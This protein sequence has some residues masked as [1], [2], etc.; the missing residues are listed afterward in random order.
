MNAQPHQPDR[1]TSQPPSQSPNQPP[2]QQG[3]AARQFGAQ[4]SAYL[5]SAVHSQGADLDALAELVRA[6]PGCRVLDLGSGGGHVAYVAAAA[7][8]EVTAYDLSPEMLSV[9]A[10]EA[11]RRGLAIATQQGSAERLPFADA[12]FDL[13]L[14]RYSAHHWTDFSAGLRE[15]ARVLRPDGQAAFSDVVSPGVALLDTYLQA[16]EVLRDVSHVRNRSV[17]EWQVAAAQA[18]LLA[19]AVT[20]ARLRLEFAAW[21][22]RIATPPV[23]AAA[24]RALQAATSEAVLRHFAI[25]ADGSFAIDTATMLFR[26]A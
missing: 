8:G 21:I 4:A 22:A 14:S 15:A 1:A 3:L 12:S 17:A 10:A 2:T 26:R 9:V 6:R 20:P 7:G 25:E 11:A 24:I 18:G 5:T 19:G 16:V 23:F 13:V